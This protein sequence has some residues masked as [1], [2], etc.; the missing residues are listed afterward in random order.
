MPVESTV[1]PTSV[2]PQEHILHLATGYWMPAALY[3]VTTL[4]IPDRL[5]FG[6]RTSADLADEVGVNA[7]R[8][9]RV[10]RLLAMAGLFT[11]LSPGMFALTPT[12]EVLRPGVEGTLRDYVEFIT[13]PNHFRMFSYMPEMVRTGDLGQYFAFGSRGWEY[14]EQHPEEARVFNE[15]MANVTNLF[16]P[17]LID[18]C[19]FSG[20]GT[21]VDV[22][23]GQ[24][25]LIS[26]VL[27]RYPEMKGIVFEIASVADGARL[28]LESHGLGD[29][30]SVAVG[31]FNES[32]P[33]G[34]AIMMK[35]I[36]H[37]ADD[38]G[39][40]LLLR[41]CHKALG[42]SKIG[43]LILFENVVPEGD[44][45]HFGKLLDMEMM[46]IPGGRERTANQFRNL[47]TQCGFEMTRIITTQ[48]SISVVEA[49]RR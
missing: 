2:T 38:P 9:Y 31:S 1:T 42:E 33:K 44:E 18:A 6:P 35:H 23:G 48:T 7:D 30:C 27:K 45:P 12:G 3:V 25:A 46:A 16:G 37:G 29:R 24:G 21:L 4:N 39:A 15:A 17:K 40:D 11:E 32:V 5:R 22:A 47:L 10:M 34:D 36:I 14:F 28:Y 20:I 41:N 13:D 43:K 26:M 49:V 19:D 8:L